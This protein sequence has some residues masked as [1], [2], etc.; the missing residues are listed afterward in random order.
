MKY[1]DI[2]IMLT[3]IKDHLQTITKHFPYSEFELNIFTI[4]YFAMTEIDQEIADL[5]D[6]VFSR[7]FILF[8]YPEFVE[9]NEIIKKYDNLITTYCAEFVMPTVTNKEKA[10]NG[11]IIVNHAKDKNISDLFDSIIH[12]LKHALNTIINFYNPGLTATYRIGLEERTIKN[13]KITKVTNDYIE[14]TFNCY[15]TKIYLDV[16]QRLKELPITIPII[17]DILEQFSL[18]N[19]KYSYQNITFLLIPLFQNPKLFQLFY[20]ATLYKD[21]PPLNEEIDKIF[22]TSIYNLPLEYPALEYLNQ[23]LARIRVGEELNIG[24]LAKIVESYINEKMENYALSE[25][26][27][28]KGA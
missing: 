28:K 12:E 8:N 15:L 27:I 24:N 10:N 3:Q 19:Y 18:N 9:L 25:N 26:Q 5:L 17:K 23:F 7:T 21:Y 20:N 6:E 11:F 2:N 13:N 1:M 22:A 4:I 14:E 16:I